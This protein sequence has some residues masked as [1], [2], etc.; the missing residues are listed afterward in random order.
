MNIKP[1]YNLPTENNEVR[2]G[3]SMDF[4]D[5]DAVLESLK[6]LVGIALMADNEDNAAVRGSINAM[7]ELFVAIELA[8]KI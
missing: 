5:A 6:H 4:D 3:V 2:I 7:R 8:K 1:I